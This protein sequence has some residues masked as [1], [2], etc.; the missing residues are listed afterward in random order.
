MSGIGS[1]TSSD[2]LGSYAVHGNEVLYSIDVKDVWA[3]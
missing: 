1:R 2:D 3:R